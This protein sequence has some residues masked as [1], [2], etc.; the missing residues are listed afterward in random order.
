MSDKQFLKLLA[1]SHMAFADELGNREDLRNML[2]P[3]LSCA[4][5]MVRMIL[6][7]EDDDEGVPVSLWFCDSAW[8]IKLLSRVFW[9]MYPDAE[10]IS[11]VRRIA[12]RC[13]FS[14][15]VVTGAS[16]NYPLN[17][18]GHGNITQNGL[19]LG[20][21]TERCVLALK[22]PDASGGERP[23]VS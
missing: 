11:S 9:G 2:V 17:W 13:G 20:E 5:V 12:K 14:T 10:T 18:Y 4:S 3:E 19:Y 8:F 15:V 1:Y 21:N 23:G 16:E 6:A 22:L 7:I